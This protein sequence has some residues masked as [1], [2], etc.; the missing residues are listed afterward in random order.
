MVSV[1]VWIGSGSLQEKL[2]RLPYDCEFAV[3]MIHD[4]VENS[5]IDKT[6]I[7]DYDTAKKAYDGCTI[8]CRLVKI[9]HYETVKDRIQI[10]SVLHHKKEQRDG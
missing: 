5:L 4:K 2:W 9:S 8:E 10:H 3:Q 6:E 1:P 7:M